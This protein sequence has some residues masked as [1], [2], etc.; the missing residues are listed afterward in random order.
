MYEA[1]ASIITPPDDAVIWRYMNLEKVLTLL[2]TQ[3]L[4]LCRLDQFADPWEGVWPKPFVE[5]MRKTWPQKEQDT[6]LTFSKEMRR[7]FFLNCWHE[8]AYESAALWD[9][10]AKSAGFA[11]RT[12][13][14]RLKKSILDERHLFIGKIEY[15][16]YDKQNVSELNMLIPPF[17]KRKSFQHEKEVRVMVWD[18]PIAKEGP[19]D[20]EQAQQ[21]HKLRVDLSVLIEEL[22]ASPTIDDWLMPHIRELLARFGFH[23]I[24]LVK[25]DLY[26]PHVY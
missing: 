12:T 13:V 26:A 14:G 20:W 4:F 7:S 9:Q 25:S 1:H 19:I 8:S 2:S 5:D 6:F 18:M 17:L 10:Y 11:I 15:L 16:D 24:P 3:S 21:N 22:Y 23:N